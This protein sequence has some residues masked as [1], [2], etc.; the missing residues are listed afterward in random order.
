MG[1]RIHKGDVSDWCDDNKYGIGMIE[2]AVIA[3]GEV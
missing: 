3:A 1:C 2:G